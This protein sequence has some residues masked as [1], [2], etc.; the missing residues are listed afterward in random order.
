MAASVEMYRLRAILEALAL[1]DD[2]RCASPSFSKPLDL[3][4]DDGVHRH[5]STPP[6]GGSG[7]GAGDP[8]PDANTPPGT[9]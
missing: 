3:F 7:P 2:H 1:D 8:K 4:S 6:G 5:N 9:P